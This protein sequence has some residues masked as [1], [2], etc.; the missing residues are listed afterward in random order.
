MPGPEPPSPGPSPCRLEALPRLLQG[1][2]SLRLTTLLVKH[3][4]SH[5]GREGGVVGRKGGEG[6]L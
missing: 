6:I 1:R 3:I 2:E 5:L 4:F